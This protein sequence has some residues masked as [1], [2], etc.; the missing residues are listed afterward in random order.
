[1]AL[2]L[3]GAATYGAELANRIAVADR[4]PRRLIAIFFVL[5]VVAD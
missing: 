5:R 1:M 4:E 3:S 2:V